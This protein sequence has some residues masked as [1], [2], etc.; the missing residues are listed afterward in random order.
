MLLD[1]PIAGATVF[2][3]ANGNGVLDAGEASA[4]TTVTGAFAL[5]AAGGELIGTGGIDTQTGVTVPGPLTAPAGSGIIDPLTT[6]LD[7][8]AAA[9]GQ[10]A[11]ARSPR[12]RRCSASTRP[13]TSRSSTRRRR[14]RRATIAS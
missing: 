13:P 4:S 3:D 11:Q 5:P 12:Y 6:L 8:Y 10:T 7:A 1:G 14:R 9:T 2:A